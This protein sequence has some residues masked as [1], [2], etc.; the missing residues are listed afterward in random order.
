MPTPPKRQTT[1]KLAVA[2]SPHPTRG[3]AHFLIPKESSLWVLP[4]KFGAGVSFPH[5]VLDLGHLW[6]EPSGSL[7]PQSHPRP[8]AATPRLPLRR[9][10]L[11][12]KPQQ[13]C[14]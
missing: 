14:F 8:H 13:F 2:V 1:V 6:S 7:S 5:F 10:L 3:R 9:I 4:L 11:L 12:P